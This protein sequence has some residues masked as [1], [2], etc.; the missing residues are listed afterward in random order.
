M[1]KNI[2]VEQAYSGTWLVK[3]DSERFGKDAIIFEHY[4]C[5]KAVEYAKTIE[6]TDIPVLSR[7]NLHHAVKHQVSEYQ[8][9]HGYSL[10][11]L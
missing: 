11:Q 3:A 6:G 1:Y 2:R 10:S 7:M 9:D 5:D 4:D 8:A